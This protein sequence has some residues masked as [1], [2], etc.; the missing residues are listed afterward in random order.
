[1]IDPDP[2]YNATFYDEGYTIGSPYFRT[3][4]GAHEYSMSLY[5]TYDQCGNVY[6]W[7]EAVILDEYRGARGGSF[8]AADHNLGAEARH[9]IFRPTFELDDIG[10][11][12]ALVPEPTTLGLLT[13]GGIALLR[14]RT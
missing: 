4:V 13:L 6:E 3:E 5:G 1:M 12:I 2:G 11:R 7:N 8:F 10:F 14:R 9:Y